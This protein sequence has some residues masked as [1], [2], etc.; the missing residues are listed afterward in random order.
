MAHK[1]SSDDALREEHKGNNT[2]R[3]YTFSD[4]T[5]QISN[6]DPYPPNVFIERVLRTNSRRKRWAIVSRIN[7]KRN[8]LYPPKVAGPFENLDAAKA[9]YIIL[10]ETGVLDKFKLK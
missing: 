8:A 7:A 9:V 3:F 5:Q 2:W 6:A 4:G 10:K 1:S